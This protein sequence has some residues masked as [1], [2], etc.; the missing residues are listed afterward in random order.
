MTHGTDRRP[1]FLDLLHM[2]GGAVTFI[3]HR[4]T[5]VLLA[6]DVP[7]KIYLLDLHLRSPEGYA[8]PIALIHGRFV[9]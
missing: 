6:T 5:G 9:R 8:D 4:V 3:T 1:M 2:P 7:F